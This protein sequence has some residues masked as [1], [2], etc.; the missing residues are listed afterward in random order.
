MASARRP[1]TAP[2]RR[3]GTSEGVHREAVE[4]R[5]G[6][7][8]AAVGRR[9]Y[10]RNWV[11]GTSGNFSVVLRRRPLEL[12]VT[13]SAAHKGTLGG[14][15]CLR[16]DR[17][18]RVLGRRSARPSAETALHLAIVN[19]RGAGAVLHTHSLWGTILSDLHASQGG[20]ALQG[21]EMLKGLA[22]V[23]THEHREWVPIVENDQDV[24]RLAGVVRERLA[25][26]AG[27]HAFLIRA[28]GLYTWGATV[29]DAER[30][31]EILEFLLETLGRREAAHGNRQNPRTEP[32][33]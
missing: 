2:V 30:H 9:F 4:R 5:L 24:A 6:R 1:R 32:H 31:V 22:G 8:L 28:H 7:E 21:Y 3:T 13:P 15:D 18:G 33:D 17:A 10:A 11:L 25:A 29:A 16:V 12:L 23:R 27:A 14:T 19:A 20:L 26:E